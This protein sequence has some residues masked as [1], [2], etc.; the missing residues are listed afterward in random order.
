MVTLLF[1]LKEIDWLVLAE[2]RYRIIHV[3]FATIL[4][5]CF[6]KNMDEHSKVL[7]SYGFCPAGILRESSLLYCA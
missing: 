4:A 6:S 3:C 5:D 2:L 7:K 1:S